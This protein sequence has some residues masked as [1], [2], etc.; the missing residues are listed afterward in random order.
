MSR[1]ILH[2][3]NNPCPICDSV[4]GNCKTS[5]KGIVLCHSFIDSDAGVPAW[6]WVK[7]DKSGVWGVFVPNAEQ[8]D[9]D[10][11][12]WKQRQAER[13]AQRQRENQKQFATALDIPG[14]DRA[15]RTLHKYL[16]LSSLHR[17]NLRTRGLSDAQI[18]AGYFFTIYP[19]HKL[20][21]GIPANLPGVAWG[22]LATKTAGLACPAFDV[23][24]RI[25]GWQLRVDETTDNKYR[26]AKGRKSSH[27]PNGE[28]PITVCRPVDGVKRFGVR[29]CEGLLKPFIAAQKTGQICIG[30]AGGNFAGSH[31]QLKAALDAINPESVTL[32]ADAGAVTNLHI[33]RQYQ[34]TIELVTQ[35][36]YAVN[37][38]WWG[39]VDKSHPDIDELAEIEA[40]ATITPQEFFALSQ[41]YLG[42]TP[43][44]QE[45]EDCPNRTINR[46]QWEIKFGFGKC[47][48]NRIKQALSGFKGFG[49]PHAPKATPNEAL[50]YSQPQ[51]LKYHPAHPLPRPEDFVNL[52]PP[53]I[54]FE[55]GHRHEVR[56]KLAALGW[57]IAQD[58]SWMGTGKSHEMGQ[59]HPQEG[60][61]K[62]WYFDLNHRNPST[63]TV[64]GMTDMPPRHNGLAAIPGRFTPSGQPHLKWAGS[65]DELMVPSLCHN[66]ELFTR[67][68]QKG[69]NPDF[70]KEYVKSKDGS[71]SQNRN[72]ICKECPFSW[73]CHSEIGDGYGYLFERRRAMEAS[74][75]RA[76]LDSAPNPD[77]YDYS[78]DYAAVEE[79]S[80][81]LRGTKTLSS[82]S[83]DLEQC[84]GFVETNQ[85]DT[86]NQLHEF[87][88]ALR[89]IVNGESVRHGIPHEDLIAQLPQPT[90]TISTLAQ[91]VRAAMPCVKDA[92]AIADTVTG[93]GG[94]WR[95]LGQTARNHFKS[96]A[97]K[98]TKQNIENLPV[99]A[100]ADILEVWA[101]LKHGSLRFAKGE[102]HCTVADTRHADI[103]SSCRTVT[104]LDATGDKRI[105]AQKLGV[106]PHSIIQIEQERPLLA[107]LRVVRASME[108]MGSNN[109]SEACKRRQTAFVNWAQQ[110]HQDQ[111]IKVIANKADQHLPQKDGWWFHDNLSTNAYEGA[112]VLVAFNTPRTNL[113]VAQDEYRVLF[114]TLDGFEQYY[115]HLI[116]E[117]ITQLIGRQRCHR[118]PDEQFVVY[119]VGN[120]NQDVS[121]LSSEYGLTVEA[122]EAFQLCPECGTEIQI[123]HWRI[124]DAVRQLQEQKQ[125]IT[126]QALA[127][128]A[129]ITQGRLSQI[130][131]SLGGW[132]ALKKILASLLGVYRGTNNFSDLT[133]EEK[134]MASSF[135]PIVLGEPPDNAI[136]EVGQIIQA[137]GL[138]V[139]LRI[140]T[141]ATP[142][143]Q[144][145]LLALLIQ[146]LPVSF[147]SELLAWLETVGAT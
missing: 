146:A 81:V 4:L 70:E 118:Y 32:D 49:K 66:A 131:D 19:D 132:L 99:N 116:N 63:A 88:L 143:T 11:E 145:R 42:Y 133:D 67:L 137:Y 57:R 5:D 1:F 74:R 72:P 46:E 54:I 8:K 89:E 37:V 102:L 45:L 121:F 15:I 91:L 140:L 48:R 92:I 26:W 87:R 76:N 84:W 56:A 52:E 27:L 130:A 104:L 22:K 126:Q 109:I 58:T 21:P 139:F 78:S 105:L 90:E 136:H 31:E 62:L 6:I 36:G 65:D 44:I 135:L 38:A 129:K 97:A 128:L 93:V 101:G 60:D 13:D 12:Q 41:Q 98:V 141:A 115:Q 96:E 125:K 106:S 2:K 73:K 120:P 28:L 3:R 40:I 110:H 10:R 119:L 30:A 144:A 43:S 75:I 85:P 113:G 53:K 23:S 59:L 123:T 80:R 83:A 47:L 142:K 71:P 82:T 7:S 16:G 103:L 20:P 24:G 51:T 127:T 147:Q 61:G 100:L 64:E 107:N 77:D 50:T 124:L 35:W 86:F 25:I 29:L 138:S 122:V 94:K 112:S 111:T 18:E 95:N 134:W 55:P 114:G 9:F 69:Y 68:K 79:A 14:R 39:Q 108:G 117:Q 33:I 17:Q 34:R